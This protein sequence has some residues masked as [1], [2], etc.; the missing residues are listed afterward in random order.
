M[1]RYFVETL[2]IATTSRTTINTPI[3]VQIHIP[4]PIH[5][6]AWFITETLSFGSA[7]LYFD[8]FA[9]RTHTLA[10]SI[11][12]SL[13]LAAATMAALRSSRRLVQVLLRTKVEF[14][15]ALGTAEVIGLSFMLASPCGGS[16][17][18]VHAADRIFHSCCAIHYDLP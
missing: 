3:N 6:Y 4:P 13:D 1:H 2:L 9:R 11:S 12:S 15:F 18:D 7:V 17:F 16:R 10:Q 14:L 5:P 8:D